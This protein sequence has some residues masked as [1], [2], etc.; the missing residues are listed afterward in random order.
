MGQ[1]VEGK[2]MIAPRQLTSSKSTANEAQYLTICTLLQGGPK[3]TMEFR[4]AGVM[5]PA[6]RIKE[7]NERHGYEIVRTGLVE[8]WDEWGFKHSRIAVYELRQIPNEV[9]LN[10]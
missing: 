9:A 7:M 8:L 3:N 1:I 5:M 2:A 4:R 6:A 10:G